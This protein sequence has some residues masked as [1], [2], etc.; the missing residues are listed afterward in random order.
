M[1][2]PALSTDRDQQQQHILMPASAKATPA[3]RHAHHCS[4]CGPQHRHTGKPA[5]T[6]THVHAHTRTHASARAHTY[7]HKR[8]HT[9]THTHARAQTH[10]HTRA[11]TYTHAHMHMHA[12]V[13]RVMCFANF[14]ASLATLPHLSFDFLPLLSFPVLQSSDR[15]AG[16]GG[17]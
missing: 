2:A 17:P 16:E 3:Q 11:Q 5:H 9:Y 7:K 15:H 14:L 6:R 10:G 4:I 8:A 1:L 12:H 13:A